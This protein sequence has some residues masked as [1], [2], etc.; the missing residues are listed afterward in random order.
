MDYIQGSFPKRDKIFSPLQNN[1]TGSGYQVP[2][3]SVETAFLS[4]RKRQRREPD[5][6]PASG[7]E[8]KNDWNHI[9]LSLHDTMAS[10]E[11]TKFVCKLD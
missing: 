4:W 6:L 11:D 7:V 5:H 2:P 1:H 8:G 10:S 3:Y 9:L